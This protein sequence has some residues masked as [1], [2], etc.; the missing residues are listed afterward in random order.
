MREY[1]GESL[2]DFVDNYTVIDIE[3]TGLCPGYDEIIELAAVRV[4]KKEI[5]ETFNYLIKPSR[6]INDFITSLTGITNEMLKDAFELE[7]ILP[8]YLD[9]LGESILVGHNVHFDINFIYDNSMNLLGFPLCNNFIDILRLSRNL[10]KSLDNHKLPTIAREL[11]IDCTR[12]HRALDDCITAQKCYESIKAIGDSYYSRV[13][14]RYIEALKENNRYM[15]IC[16]MFRSK[17]VAIKGSFSC[18]DTGTIIKMLESIGSKPSYNLY[19]SCEYVI[20]SNKRADEYQDIENLKIIGEEDFYDLFR[21]P[22]KKKKQSYINF[23]DYNIKVSDIIADPKKF[24]EDNPLY[25]KVCVFTGTLEKMSRK[26]A[27]QVV[28]NIGGICSNTVTKKTNYLILGNYDY[29]CSSIK[30]GKSTKRKKAEEIILQGYD[31]T[32][33]SENEFYD[34]IQSF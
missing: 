34:I 22:P 25:N 6:P 4:E 7:A 15:Q 14:E 31:I 1:K 33:I 29:Y 24:D 10:L 3:T 8:M 17:R 28:A 11:N 30:D 5:V 2:V 9:F 26:D 12:A 27:M 19:K 23:E 13:A 18:I 32:I 16:D 20:A 21:I